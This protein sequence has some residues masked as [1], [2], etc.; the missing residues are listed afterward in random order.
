MSQTFDHAGVGKELS[1]FQDSSFMYPMRNL[2]RCKKSLLGR[3]E[4]HSIVEDELLLPVFY[5]RG[6]RE[7]EVTAS[8]AQVL[9]HWTWST[10]RCERL[11][12]VPRRAA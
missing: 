7:E 9:L 12:T 6:C 1:Q 11:H 4:T 10:R 3:A 2:F 8:I 5:S